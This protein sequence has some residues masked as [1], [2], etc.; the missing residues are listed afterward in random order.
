MT[1]KS[2]PSPS[3]RE[4][5]AALVAFGEKAYD[6]MYEVHDQTSAAACYSDAKEAYY[7]AIS[8][9]Q[10]LGLADEAEKLEKRLEHIKAVYR[11]QFWQG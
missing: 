4:R 6:Q 8:L 11:S 7:D 10:R 9:A 3:D 2:A 5:L 1:E